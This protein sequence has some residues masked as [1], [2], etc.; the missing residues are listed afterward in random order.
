MFL[1][2]RRAEPLSATVSPASRPSW[3]TSRGTDAED[4]AGRAT[5]EAGAAAV[6]AGA[7]V[8]IAPSGLPAADVPRHRARLV[9]IARRTGLARG[10]R[11]PSPGTRR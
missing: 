4:A 2:D 8:V 6:L 10:H 1:R 9:A 3:R 5:G 11:P 7:T